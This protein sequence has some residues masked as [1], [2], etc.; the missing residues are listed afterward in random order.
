MELPTNCQH[1]SCKMVCALIIM[2]LALVLMCLPHVGNLQVA[3]GPRHAA[4]LTR[5]GEVYTWGSGMGGNG[6]NGTA[7]GS[8][9][10][11]QVRVLLQA[12]L[13]TWAWCCLC[14]AG[15]SGHG[16]VRAGMLGCAS[17]LLVT[18]QSLR[19]LLLLLLARPAMT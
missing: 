16:D 6:G 2:G 5:G 14:L 15:L 19:S 11:Q 17:A 3:V 8:N 18:A 1:T 12:G 7:A 9:H 13:P 10:P 4:L